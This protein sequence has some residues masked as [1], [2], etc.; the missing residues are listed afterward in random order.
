MNSIL[1]PI[2]EPTIRREKK[3]AALLIRLYSNK[4]HYLNLL[5]ITKEI[6]WTNFKKYLRVFPH[7]PRCTYIV[8]LI[9]ITQW[10]K[11]TG[12]LNL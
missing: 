7:K 4:C 6:C 5:L 3:K 9:A 12:S 1:G 10:R 11:T 8:L 2:N